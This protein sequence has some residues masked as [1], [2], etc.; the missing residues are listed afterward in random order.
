M[1][2]ASYEK[3]ADALV[4]RIIA[5]GPQVL[6]VTDAW[7]LF[8]IKGFTCEDL[9]PSLAQADWALMKAKQKLAAGTE[10]TDPTC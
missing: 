5:L 3:T 6:A 2:R 9:Q 7:A 10:R 4:D 8:K 1:S